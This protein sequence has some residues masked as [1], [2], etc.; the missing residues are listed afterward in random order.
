MELSE[1][2][3][4][5]ECGTKKGTAFCISKNR[6]LT[7]FHV[8]TES[9]DN[10]IICTDNSGKKIKVYLS[11]KVTENY[12][13]LDIAMLELETDIQ[14]IGEYNFTD[15][16]EIKSGT[17]WT[18][19]GFPLAKEITGDNVLLGDSYIVNQQL[20]TLRN[21]KIDIE[22]QHSKKLSTY[23]G[24]SGSPLVINGSIA[25][26]I[27]KELLENGESK[28]L[29]A[30][31]IKHFKELLIGEGVEVKEKETSVCTPLRK[32]LS[33]E[34][35][36]R[37]IEKSVSDLGVR[38]TPE[39]NLE[40]SITRRFDALLRNE[41]FYDDVKTKFHDYLIKI[42][43]FIESITVKKKQGNSAE[44]NHDFVND[45][46]IDKESIQDHYE[47][48]ISNK[49]NSLDIN[50]LMDKSSSIDEVV[51][52]ALKIEKENQKSRHMSGNHYLNEAR[53]ACHAFHSF[54]NMSDVNLATSPYLLIKG[55]AGTGKSH[56]LA[57]IVVSQR[58]KNIPSILLLGQHFTSDKSPWSQII[59]DLLRLG[60]SESEL[61]ETLN[62]IGKEKKQRIL[63][64]IDAIN[65]GRGKYFWAEH[66]N[67]FVNL[68][69]KYPWISLVITIRDT[70][71][72]KII[73]ENFYN[74]TQMKSATHT[75]FS[76][77]EYEAV[78]V[79][80]NHYHIN[81]P[82][83]PIINPEFSNPLFLK[84]FC[85]GLFKR[86]LS[87]VPEGYGGISSVMN[88][89]ID[90]IDIKLGGPNYYN[91]GESRKV[92][93]KIV[94]GLIKYKQNNEIS[95]VPYDE[96]C[97]IA[98]D[99]IVRYTHEKGII[100]DLVH[101]GLFSKNLHWLDD[102]EDE[103]GI[104]FAYERLD[105]HFSAE[106]LV[107]EVINH[108]NINELLKPNGQL[109][110]LIE[111]DYRYQGLIEALSIQLPE[112]YGKE[113]FE[114]VDTNERE[115][116]T[117]INAFINSLRWRNPSTINKVSDQYV[118][119]TVLQYA[120][121]FEGFIE[122]MYAV[123]GDVK[124]PYNA[125]RLHKFLTSMSLADRDSE[126]TTFLKHR[127]DSDSA[128]GRLLEWILLSNMH[129]SLSDDSTLLIGIATA[130]LCAS[131]NIELRNKATKALSI[132]LI[133][134]LGVGVNLLKVFESIDDPYVYER[135][136]AAL[137]GASLNTIVLSGLSELAEY[138]VETIFS[139]E[140][141]YPNVL[142]RDYA[143]NIVEF[144]IFKN[145]ITLNKPEVIRPPYNSSIPDN[146]PSDEETDS[147]KF[148][149]DDKGFKDEYWSQNRIIS[150]MITEY[151]RGMCSYGD[152]GRY[153]FQSSLSLWKD[154]DPNPLSN[155]A[156]KLIFEK[157]GYD[158]EIH[159][160]FDKYAGEG[161]RFENKVERIGKKYQWLALYEVTARLADNFKVKDWDGNDA[162]YY[163][164]PWQNSL[165]NIDPT[166][167]PEFSKNK[168]LPI[169]ISNIHYDDWDEDNS[170]WLLSERNLPNPKDMILKDNFLSLESNFTWKQP[171]KLGVDPNNS[172]RKNMW[173][174]V[175]SYLVK[176][177]EFESLKSWLVEQDFMGR[178]LPESNENYSIFSKEHYWSPA[179]KDKVSENDELCWQPIEKN[180]YDWRNEE[181]VA[182]V[183]PTAEEHRWEDKEG[184]SFLAPRAEMFDGMKL[185][186]SEIPSCWFDDNGELV[187]F[188]PH[189]FGE[190]KSEL[191]VN[192]SVLEKFLEDKGMKIIWTVLGEKQVL[193][194]SNTNSWIDMSGVYYLE[195]DSIEG[196]IT[197]NIKEPG[198][199]SKQD[200]GK[201]NREVDFDDIFNNLTESSEK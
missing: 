35:F 61:L 112:K 158:V 63:F 178:W 64:S 85:E 182:E 191:L 93:R 199:K 16:S 131:T 186:S 177:D 13:K 130:W 95:Y 153:T 77:R 51:S 43:K 76:G 125:N 4:K 176:D 32:M 12:K 75:G 128:I 41:A 9:V 28:E 5:I 7:A 15:Y 152:F 149:W 138:I 103:E 3:F 54:L 56:L 45:V 10:E 193:G 55:K 165:R 172:E 99:T 6:V 78:K 168:E 156:C 146:F 187:C 38:Y 101:E 166:H 159:G 167:P 37:H 160:M 8:V 194:S 84:L 183:L 17:Y 106:L 147:F 53:N 14:V 11:D 24:Y 190:D 143:R 127:N 26:I 59:D 181:V 21:N 104:Y 137:Y 119:E 151:G 120:E 65:E 70:Y 180:R 98:N 29:T 118:N 40:T 129:K 66:L 109:Y 36:N 198:W 195:G 50:L 132:I 22:L 133:G 57:D 69:K 30:L 115:E 161:D 67:S 163:Q 157:F 96:A 142:V 114:L 68:F 175:R 97:D 171:E 117:I 58:N 87:Q 162:G 121:P 188:D 155:Y 200:N 141:V 47:E 72:R 31:S 126:W 122:L 74:T 52:S 169:H 82:K 164:G 111:E 39:V 89:F 44:N 150:S 79:F 2:V 88:Y 113:L 48:F 116:L 34:W 92:C 173:Y 174:Q 148:E 19:R 135:I 18:S 189:V 94:N 71:L 90:N 134:R 140:E 185:S 86:G 136:L 25:G 197:V 49:L 81:L 42:N 1:I 123:A 144:A 80:F 107:D 102:G 192:K 145:K 105:D 154:L 110:Y 46:I 108:E 196:S 170:L 139:K 100:E 91:Y 179:Y 184:T 62:E 60:C 20:K 23:A 83:T 73:P 27:N 124:H 201:I 33:N